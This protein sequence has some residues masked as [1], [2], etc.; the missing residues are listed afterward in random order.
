[1]ITNPSA[2]KSQMCQKFASMLAEARQQLWMSRPQM[3]RRL[4]VSLS[5]YLYWEGAHGM[6]RG[7]GPEEMRRKI[8]AL[9]ASAKIPWRQTEQLAA[10]A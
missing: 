9:L 4:R 8:G 2:E 3:A 6:P 1:M 7:D 10:A 5:S